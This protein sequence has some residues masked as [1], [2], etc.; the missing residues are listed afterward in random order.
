MRR[1]VL[2]LSVRAP[3]PP[4]AGR[5]QD[6]GGA[7][8]AGDEEEAPPPGDQEGRSAPAAAAAAVPETWRRERN[9]ADSPGDHRKRRRF[10][11][12]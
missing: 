2:L 12:Q 6:P 3:K 8:P 9:M 1:R 11:V 4:G 7:L 5:V 10:G